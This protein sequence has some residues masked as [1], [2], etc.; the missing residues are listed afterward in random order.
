MKANADTGRPGQN[1]M[2]RF[3]QSP[4]DLTCKMKS[5]RIAIWRSSM[6]IGIQEEAHVKDLSE[7]FMT[8]QVTLTTS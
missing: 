1:P 8:L 7:L 3:E 4:E 5:C 6:V 2:V